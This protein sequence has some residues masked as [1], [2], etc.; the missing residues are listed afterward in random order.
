MAYEDYKKREKKEKKKEKK[1]THDHH[2][3][4]D[5]IKRRYHFDIGCD[6]CYVG[7]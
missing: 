4:M 5:G 7:I 1:R 2:I 3:C 6:Q